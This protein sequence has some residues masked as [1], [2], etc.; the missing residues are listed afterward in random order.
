LVNRGAEP[1]FVGGGFGVGGEVV[2][3]QRVFLQVI[4]LFVAVDVAAVLP[5][6]VAGPA[7]E[8]G[9]VEVSGGAFQ[10]DPA[11]RLWPGVVDGIKVAAGERRGPVEPAER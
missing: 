7:P 6:A 4:E 9:V 1:F 8:R 2:E 11:G 5:L 3:L 10:E